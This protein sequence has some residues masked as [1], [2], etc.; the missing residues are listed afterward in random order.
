MPSACGRQGRSKHV[1]QG[2]VQWDPRAQAER[3]AEAGSLP[4][5][6]PAEAGGRS[7]VSPLKPHQLPSEASTP[8]DLESSRVWRSFMYTAIIFR[9]LHNL[10]PAWCTGRI[11]CSEEWCMHFFRFQIHSVHKYHMA[12]LHYLI[13]I[14]SCK[15]FTA[16]TNIDLYFASFQL[17]MLILL[18]EL[19]LFGD[20]DVIWVQAQSAVCQ[21]PLI[22]V[23]YK[24]L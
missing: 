9:H 5:F 24:P 14:R 8:A 7:Q 12:M 21:F 13:W 3:G 17:I 23:I 16:C 1:S 20:L 19:Q 11:F 4:Q 22:G 2:S 15:R 10:E 18:N 6:H